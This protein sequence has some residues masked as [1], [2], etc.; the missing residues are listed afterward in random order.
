MPSISSPLFFQVDYLKMVY[1]ITRPNISQNLE[2]LQ[3]LKEA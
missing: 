3:F 1:L 2:K